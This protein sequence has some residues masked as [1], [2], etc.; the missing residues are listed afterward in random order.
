MRE[1]AH[2]IER[3]VLDAHGVVFSNSFRNVVSEIAHLSGQ[4]TGEVWEKWLRE[5][6]YPAW[7]GGLSE[8]EIWPR[9]GVGHLTRRRDE[10]M[11][12]AFGL[13]PAGPY[14]RTWNRHTPI[15]LLSNHRSEWL[16]PR[17]QQFGL[18]GFFERILIS[19]QTGFVKPDENAFLEI[20]D[21]KSPDRVL[22]VDDKQK[23]I[24][25]AK[26]LGACTILATTDVLWTN[27][28]S[29]LLTFQST[30]AGSATD[31]VRFL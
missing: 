31:R 17:L 25:V 5:V 2:R 9:L 23:N 4:N 12:T 14:L 29:E 20:M 6:R 27:A 30:P 24:D 19:D 3:L 18:E 11:R 21:G 15:W 1:S 13:G 28:I 16:R 7:S 10:I 22:Y 26:R 8:S